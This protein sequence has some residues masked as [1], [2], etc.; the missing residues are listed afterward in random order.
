MLAFSTPKSLQIQ[1]YFIAIYWII[2]ANYPQVTKNLARKELPKR[3]TIF[4]E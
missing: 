3:P 1:G 4:L 2:V